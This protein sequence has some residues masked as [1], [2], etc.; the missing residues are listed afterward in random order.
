[1]EKYPVEEYWC[2]P[3]QPLVSQIIYY[4]I[5]TSLFIILSL[6]SFRSTIEDI[7][8]RKKL[9]VINTLWKRLYFVPDVETDSALIRCLI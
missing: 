2:E 3:C 9:R 7:E 1:M 4:L 5:Q 6:L 8:G